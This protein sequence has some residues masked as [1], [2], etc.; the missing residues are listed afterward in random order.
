MIASNFDFYRHFVAPHKLAAAL[1]AQLARNIDLIDSNFAVDILAHFV[2][3]RYHFES[4]VAV[5]AVAIY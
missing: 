4:V 1:A 3:Y 5:V 2:T